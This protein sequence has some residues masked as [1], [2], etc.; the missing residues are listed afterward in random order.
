MKTLTTKKITLATVKSFINK[1]RAN[2]F[3]N[4]KS[5]FDGMTDGIESLHAGFVPAKADGTKAINPTDYGN[6]TQGI[7]GVW[8]VGDS[9]DYFTAFE[10][11][12]LIGYEVT[13]SCGRFIVA[14]AK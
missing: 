11:E 9:R 13:N 3:I 1:N 14:I 4:V 7:E 12:T 5:S 10:N 2:L 6:N 8:F